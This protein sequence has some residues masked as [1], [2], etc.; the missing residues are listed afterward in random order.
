MYTSFAGK[1][2]TPFNMGNS[3]E[4]EDS[5]REAEV[6]QLSPQ[7]QLL[8][9]KTSEFPAMQFAPMQIQHIFQSVTEADVSLSKDFHVFLS[10]N[11]IKK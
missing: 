10:R 3:K 9:F 7:N 5:I 4:P 2:S 1:I 6:V 11:G 8:E